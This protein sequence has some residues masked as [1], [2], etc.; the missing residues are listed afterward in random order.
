[1]EVNERR[2]RATG[3]MLQ[4]EGFF[5]EPAPLRDLRY[6]ANN[7]LSKL[8]LYFLPVKSVKDGSFFRSRKKKRNRFSSINEKIMKVYT[9]YGKA[10]GCNFTEDRR[11]ENIDCYGVS[12]L[13]TIYN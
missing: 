13:R 4:V 9:G 11:Q 5:V 1:M 8:M 10:Y 3:R 12:K 6:R 7:R 2:R